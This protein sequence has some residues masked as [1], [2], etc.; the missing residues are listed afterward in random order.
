MELASQAS[1]SRAGFP[2]CHSRGLPAHQA[3]Q[4][5]G[6]RPGARPRGPTLDAPP[7]EARRLA[8][9]RRGRLYAA[10]LPP[11]VPFP[12]PTYCLQ[13]RPPP[14][15]QHRINELAPNRDRHAGE[16]GSLE[17]DFFPTRCG[18]HFPGCVAPRG[19]LWVVKLLRSL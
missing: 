18:L 4:G 13:P 9:G 12:G 2:S 19:D 7:A 10:L 11:C 6:A 1:S 3:A 17:S 15:P 16:A 8:P 5:P 14:W